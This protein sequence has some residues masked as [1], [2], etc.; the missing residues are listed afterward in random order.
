MVR[1]I[2]LLVLILWTVAFFR[3]YCQVKVRVYPKQVEDG[4]QIYSDNYEDYP[5]TI[6]IVFQLE[7]LSR[8]DENNYFVVPEYSSRIGLCGLKT[9]DSTKNSNVQLTYRTQIGNSFLTEFDKDFEYYLPF[10][11]GKVFELFQGYNGSESHIGILALDFTMPL[12]TKIHAA[13]GGKVV[14]VVDGNNITCEEEE[15]TKYNNY[16]VIMHSDGTFAEYHHIKMNG[17]KVKVGEMVEI[18]QLI[19]E[20]GN[21][22]YSK[23]PHLHFAVYLQ[24]FDH[25]ETVSTKFRTGRNGDKIKELVPGGR[26]SRNYE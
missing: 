11:K 6:Q 5:V 12:G 10:E 18:G 26:Y 22:G 21:V 7:N 14:K 15:C 20:S 1:Q 24:K 16:V 17:S 25:K 2:F 3:A 8:L 19:A 9:I 13:R 23:G 4:F